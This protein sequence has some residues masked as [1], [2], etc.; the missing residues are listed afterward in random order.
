MAVQIVQA[1]GAAVR[2]EEG[3]VVVQPD[4]TPAGGHLPDLPVS[5]VAPVTAHRPG[6][7]VAGHKGLFGVQEHIPDSGVI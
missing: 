4:Q 1:G 7:G 6:V 5:E 3:G 2:A